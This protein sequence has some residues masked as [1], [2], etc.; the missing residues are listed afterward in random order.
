M[1]EPTTTTESLGKDIEH[2]TSSDRT[3]TTVQ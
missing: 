1:N 2:I 3:M